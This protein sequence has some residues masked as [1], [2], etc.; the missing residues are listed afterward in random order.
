[1]LSMYCYRRDCSWMQK[2]YRRMTFSI[3]A[4]KL[5]VLTLLM[6]TL[7]FN[8]LYLQA[9]GVS[10]IV[11]AGSM[12]CLVMFSFRLAERGFFWLQ[13]RLGIGIAFI[14]MLSCVILPDIWPLSLNLY[15]FTIGSVFYPSRL[16]IRKLEDP[17]IFTKLVSNPATVIE[18]YYSR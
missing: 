16:L 18:G 14:A 6:L 9:Y 11:G 5:F 17:E 3:S 7:I 15:I 2:F 1:M 12:L 13:K 4:R 10:W 8:F